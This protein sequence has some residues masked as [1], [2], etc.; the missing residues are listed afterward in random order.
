MLLTSVST[1]YCSSSYAIDYTA[2]D[3]F[4]KNPIAML[5][6]SLLT[7]PIMSFYNVSTKRPQTI[8]TTGK[9]LWYYISYIAVSAFAMLTSIDSKK[10]ATV[11]TG[12]GTYLPTAVIVQKDA[13]SG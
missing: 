13:S 6:A 7:R 1:A 2:A 10:S 4:A 12:A 3:I 5:I 11:E 9:G 8:A